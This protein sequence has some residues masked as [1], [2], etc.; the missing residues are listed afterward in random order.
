MLRHPEEKKAK[1]VLLD[2]L[3]RGKISEAQNLFEIWG[4]GLRKDPRIFFLL[5]GLDKKIAASGGARHDFGVS[6]ACTCC[7][8][9]DGETCCG[10]GIENKYT[11]RILL[12]NLLFGNPLPEKRLWSNGCFF[13][14]ENGCSLK[15]RLVLC[16]NYLCLKIQRMLPAEDLASLQEI[17][18]EEMDESFILEEAVKKFIK[19][20]TY[21]R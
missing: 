17:T 9:E 16:V 7:N 20:K 3:I 14:S 2:K 21:G 8:E 18:G 15:A 1:T 12:I 11:S 5:N 13:L 4:D 6:A 10:A 19:E